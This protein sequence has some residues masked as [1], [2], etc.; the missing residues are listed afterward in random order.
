M[1]DTF[2]AKYLFEKYRHW[3][4]DYKTIS[5]TLK[6][7]I[8]MSALEL[9]LKYRWFA[10]PLPASRFGGCLGF[11]WYFTC[12]FLRDTFV[13]TK[14]RRRNYTSCPFCFHFLLVF[15]FFLFDSS[16]TTLNWN[17]THQRDVV[18]VVILTLSHW[19]SFAL[20]A[21]HEAPGCF[22]QEPCSGEAQPER[23]EGKK[24]SS[25]EMPPNA[26]LIPHTMRR[27]NH[28]SSNW[29]LFSKQQTFSFTSEWT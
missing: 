3:S 18:L 6:L 14:W 28:L 16:Y 1:L 15:F 27:W 29:D 23:R 5:K 17:H 11:V 2:L 4:G 12:I 13:T 7:N 21:A 8:V 26:N 24:K 19:I 9:A 10:W 22:S 25:K 20:C